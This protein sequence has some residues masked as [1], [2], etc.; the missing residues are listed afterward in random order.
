LYDVVPWEDKDRVEHTLVMIKPDTITESRTRA[1][2]VIDLFAKTGLCIIGIK[3]IHISVAQAM[4]FYKPVHEVFIEKFIGRVRDRV[5]EAL[6][7]AFDF[8]IPED[9]ITTTAESLRIRN[10]DHEF[11][12]I[13][14]FIT[15]RSPWEIP[16]EQWSEPGSET[17][18]ALV[19]Q[20]TDAIT[21]IRE[22]LGS[23]D[24]SKAAP[25]TVRKEFGTDVMVNTAHASDSLENAKRE[26]DILNLESNDLPA[27]VA[28][29]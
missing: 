27:L 14:T 9:T 15:G 6:Q 12:R 1:G 29:D 8:A 20:G 2:T 28:H 26:I 11:G 22:Q 18:L 5:R 13:V 21:R 4:E 25:A 19:Y 17:C 10:A 23:T 24:P 16:E 7:D 3:V